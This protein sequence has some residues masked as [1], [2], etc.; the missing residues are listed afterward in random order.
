MLATALAPHHQRSHGKALVWLDLVQGRARIGDLQQQGSAK[1]IVPHIGAVPEVVFLNTSGGLTGGDTLAYTLRCG[2]G[3]RV[4]GTSQTAERAYRAS[5]GTAQV[6]VHLDVGAQG[7]LDWLPQETILFNGASLARKTRIDLGRGA[8]CLV[9]EQVVLGRA[10]MGETVTQ[11][12]FQDRREIWREGRLL[13]LEPLHMDSAALQ[14]GRAVLGGEVLGGEVL[15]GADLGGADLGNM[16]AF[17]SMVMVGGDL[18]LAALRAVLDE[19][20]VRAGASQLDG[21]LHLRM[22]ARD[23]WPMRK[24]ILRAL[25]VLRRAPPPRVWQS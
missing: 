1:V 13:A 22:V 2:A 4:V 20:G 6:Q 25:E 3:L 19:P 12:A 7:W 15:G 21:R 24:Q 23:G 17:A 11:L 9:L 10:A 5:A 16:R 8:G 18:D 14:A